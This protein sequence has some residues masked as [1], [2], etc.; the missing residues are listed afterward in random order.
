MKVQELLMNIRNKDFNLES[1]LQVKK[2]LPM[3][4]KRTIAQ[5]I[6][7]E[8]ANDDDGVIKID[9]VQRY[10]SYVK[11]MITMHTNLEYTDDDYDALCSVEYRNTNLLNAIMACFGEDANECSRILNLVT[12]DYMRDV[13]IEF[14][15]AK[16]LNNLNSLIGGF[17][18]KINQK[19]DGVNIEDMIPGDVDMKQLSEFLNKY[20]K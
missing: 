18:D 4:V 10:L 15:I 11:Y 13:S 14:T 19:I 9:S 6:I 1:G 2:Y 12:D 3:E 16:F 20:I 7:Y 8:C 17:A 5:G